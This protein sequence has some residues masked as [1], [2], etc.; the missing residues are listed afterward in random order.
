MMDPHIQDSDVLSYVQD[1]GRRIQY[2]ASWSLAHSGLTEGAPARPHTSYPPRSLL[3]HS[4]RGGQQ[5]YY[6]H[7]RLSFACS[8]LREC[9]EL[10]EK[11]KNMPLQQ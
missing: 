9:A 5:Q 10:D 8:F 3:S 1:T 11:R 6:H 2:T 4:F 7:V